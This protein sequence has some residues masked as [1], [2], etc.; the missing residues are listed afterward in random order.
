MLVGLRK[1][2]SD[3]EISCSLSVIGLIAHIDEILPCGFGRPEICHSTFSDDTHLVE[4][5][6]KLL[7]GLV[8]RH[9]SCQTS[10]V[11][12]QTQSLDEFECSRGIEA[13][14]RATCP[15]LTQ[16]KSTVAK[17]SLVPCTKHTS[18]RQCFC[19]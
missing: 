9:N 6:V 1:H 8:D 11:S 14:G 12:A 18:A 5:L 16:E 7:S 17:S 2:T 15:A 19:D 13:T 4:E 10:N 3:E